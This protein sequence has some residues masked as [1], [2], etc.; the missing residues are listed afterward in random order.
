MVCGRKPMDPLTLN[1][2]RLSYLPKITT[3]NQI[4]LGQFGKHP[5]LH[6]SVQ[7]FS[8]HDGFILCSGFSSLFFFKNIM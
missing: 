2:G 1:Y 7:D 8:G 5:L 3:V 6:K 4:G